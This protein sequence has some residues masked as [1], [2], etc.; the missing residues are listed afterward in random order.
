MSPFGHHLNPPHVMKRPDSSPSPALP[1]TEK[2]LVE[3]Q[4]RIARRADELTV[5]QRGDARSDL[6]RWLEAERE[7]FGV[8]PPGRSTAA[9]ATE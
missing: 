5:L 9:I 1:T 3:L 8:A 7:V 6:D 4:L 2:E